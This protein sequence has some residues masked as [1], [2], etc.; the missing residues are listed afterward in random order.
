MNR[1][2]QTKT[3]LYFLAWKQ[4]RTDSPPG[5]RNGWCRDRGPNWSPKQQSW[6]C[7][8]P[9]PSCSRALSS[10]CAMLLPLRHP[11]WNLTTVRIWWFAHYGQSGL[12]LSRIQPSRLVVPVR[13]VWASSLWRRHS[14][15][16]DDDCAT[17][18]LLYMR[19]YVKINMFLVT[20][21]SWG[22]L[23]RSFLTRTGT[24]HS[25]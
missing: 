2:K 13:L 18:M 1:R 9:S 8:R 7:T 12:I 22:C 25:W 10:S 17:G 24:T 21:F 4:F 15:V 5:C 14:W 16:S 11:M 19:V 23:Y 6:P 20:L 3:C